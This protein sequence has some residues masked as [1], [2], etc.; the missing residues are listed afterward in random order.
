M[1]QRNQ[2]SRTPLSI[3]CQVSLL[4]QGLALIPSLSVI[5]GD[6][7]ANA[8]TPSDAADP[9][10]Q[11]EMAPPPIESRPSEPEVSTGAKLLQPLQ[12][13]DYPASERVEKTPADPE[14]AEDA[15]PDPLDSA[16]VS[17]W[18][19][20]SDSA[21]QTLMAQP[22]PIGGYRREAIAPPEDYPTPET[23]NGEPTL[24]NIHQS[25]L[26]VDPTEYSLP[27]PNNAPAA[28]ASAVATQ[29]PEESDSSS[30]IAPPPPEVV[31]EGAWVE[32][33]LP[34][35]SQEMEEHRYAEDQ[36]PVPASIQQAQQANL[37]SPA[38]QPLEPPAIA[39]PVGASSAQ[40]EPVYYPEPE[41]SYATLSQVP[42]R[43]SPVYPDASVQADID[44]IHYRTKAAARNFDWKR[45]GRSSGR[46]GNGNTNMIFPL[47]IPAEIT[48]L[49]GWRN[50][51]IFGDSRF[52]SG[53]DFG[54]P[55][56]TPVVAAYSGT[57]SIADWM[58]GYGQTVVLQHQNST[59]ETLYAHLSNIF[60][61]PGE[62][63]EQG[64][65][66]GEVGSTGNSTGPHL[67][68]E[69]R[70]LTPEGWRAMDPGTQM[71]YALAQFIRSLET[72]PQIA[73]PASENSML[74]TLPSLEMPAPLPPQALLNSPVNLET[75]STTLLDVPSAPPV[76][77]PPV[78]VTLEVTIPAAE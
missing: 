58:G 38:L 24:Q 50:H 28:E 14:F 3:I 26:Y 21:E 29:T 12:G 41:A 72:A 73:T 71:E 51:P 75:A 56:G 7:D 13:A 36:L 42:V 77:L 34:Q 30:A 49:F 40:P 43:T 11:A 1:S 32:K 57:V 33:P 62:V 52:H 20:E 23:A 18:S 17:P 55:T 31:E 64:Q 39:A 45:L 54:A 4:V 53:M 46:Q 27:S 10:G 8:Q 78:P 70:E 44:G 76:P 35:A 37:Y 22:D 63:V 61:Q 6:T 2:F 69:L 19:P 60:V 59:L 9:F 74:T 47:A 67:H 16:G 65:V 25:N 15:S 66:I 5:G 48:S 68:F